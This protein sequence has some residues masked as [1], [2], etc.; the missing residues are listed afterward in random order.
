MSIR[1]LRTLLA[2]QDHGSF[3]AAAAAC[4]VTHAAVSQQMKALETLWGVA[5]FDRK[6]RRPE[7]TPTGRALAAK[8]DEII[9]AYD[10]ILASVI[11]DQGFQGEFVLGA[12]PTTL[13]GLVPLALSLLRQR[14]ADLRVTIYPGLSRQLMQQLDRGAIDAAIITRPDLLPQGLACLDIAAEPMQLL[15]PPQTDSDDPIELLRTRPFI[16]FDRNAIFGQMVEGWLQKHKITVRDSM[17]L[18]GLEAISSMVMANLGV[19]IVPK[20]CVR[21][22]NPLP[23]KRLALSGNPPA[24]QLGLAYRD[25]TPKLSVIKAGE[26][27]LL[28]AVAI[29][30][31]SS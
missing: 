19:S 17:E 31:F 24:R 15:A 11:G 14:H 4:H 22:M 6:G 13:T 8:A 23:V 26:T 16:R 29:G 28:D 7:L 27:A 3:S 18:E 2:I 1:Q 12:V 5:L 21:N 9:R 10:G 30:E 25:G 20:R